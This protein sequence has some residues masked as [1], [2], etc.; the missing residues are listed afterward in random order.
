[1]VLSALLANRRNAALRIVTRQ[2]RPDRSIVPRTLRLH[3]IDA[4][5][6]IQFEFA[7]TGSAGAYMHASPDEL[8]ITTSWW[9]TRAALG[10]VSPSQVVYLLQEDERMFYPLGDDHLRCAETLACTDIRFVVNTKLLFDHLLATGLENLKTSAMFFEPAFPDTIYRRSTRRLAGRLQF[11]FYARPNHPR[12]L[13]FRGLEAIDTAIN[14]EV[15]DLKRWDLNF[16][17]RDL[18]PITLARGV[19]PVVLTN[20]SWAD[21]GELL[22]RVDLGLSLMY[23]PHPSYPPL[24]LVASGAVAVTNRFGP[25]VDLSA[26]SSNLITVGVDV[27]A[28]VAGIAQGVNVAADAATRRAQYE[29]SRIA[30]SWEES[31]APLLDSSFLA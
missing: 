29:A 11:L 23:T 22:G 13:Y 5:S 7:D 14:Q 9:T 12:N 21:Y 30:R 24:D 27:P 15:I 28:L 1:M 18:S 10:S 31:F 8:M 26:Y 2:E 17:G 19:K 20:L 3:G 4:P 25:K 16:V 6:E